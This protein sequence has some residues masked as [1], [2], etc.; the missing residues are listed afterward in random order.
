MI[1]VRTRSLFVSNQRVR[2][3][4]AGAAGKHP[5][6]PVLRRNRVEKRPGRP[7]LRKSATISGRER[8]VLDGFLLADVNRARK[9]EIAP[10]D[11]DRA[12]LGKKDLPGLAA[13]HAFFRNGRASGA[14][15]T[16]AGFAALV[17]FRRSR[18]RRPACGQSTPVQLRGMRHC[19]VQ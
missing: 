12:M 8:M 6:E 18:R 10:G 15:Q 16:E 3:G 11:A 13:R 9:Q 2:D 5:I 17:Q 1:E 7:M 14:Q 4:R 19:M